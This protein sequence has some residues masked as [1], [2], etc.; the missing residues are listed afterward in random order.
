[1]TSIGE[2]GNPATKQ[3]LCRTTPEEAERW[4]LAAEKR[5]LTQSEF[6]RSV[7]NAAAAE[8]LDCSHPMEFR[9]SY[10]WSSFCDRCGVRL[11]G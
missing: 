2:P 1:M 7:C 5:G 8:T 9:R 11:T 3:V 6:L 4:R 10:P